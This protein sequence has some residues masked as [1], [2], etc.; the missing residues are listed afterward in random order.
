[1]LVVLSGA[2]LLI[3][4]LLFLRARPA[5]LPLRGKTVFISG[6]DSGFGFSLAVHCA[7]LGMKVVAG[8][9]TDGEGRRQLA[10]L[11]RVTVVELDVT[12]PGSVE[13][14]VETVRRVTGEEGLHCLVNNAAILVFGEA[15]W[16]TEVQARRQLE[17]N[18]LGAL[19]LTRACL[20][21]LVRGGGRV[22]NMISNCTECPLPTLAPYTAS[23]VSTNQPNTLYQ[24]QSGG[25]PRPLRGSQGGAEEV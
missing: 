21:L 19:S 10:V 6:C 4:L 24:Q 14:A 15:L 16:Q 8:C 5:N 25:A 13:A 22:V 23:K 12:K 9:F 7:Q 18:Y 20:P 17:V 11:E 3:T 1:M 2:L